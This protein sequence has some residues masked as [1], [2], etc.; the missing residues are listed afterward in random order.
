MN[1]IRNVF[2]LVLQNKVD[3]V[4]QGMTRSLKHVRLQ[5]RKGKCG[6]IVKL[7]QNAV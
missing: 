4:F 2:I 3:C 7:D 5:K 6:K 1:N